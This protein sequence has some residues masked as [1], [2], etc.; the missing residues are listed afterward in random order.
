MD[1]IAM[2]RL[3]PTERLEHLAAETASA[4]ARQK[5]MDLIARYEQFLAATERGEDELVALIREKGTAPFP[6][7]HE[8]GDIMFDVIDLIGA[9]KRFHRLLVV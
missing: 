5:L 9:R 6:N 1:A 2:V 7:Q 3:S 8:F 4:E